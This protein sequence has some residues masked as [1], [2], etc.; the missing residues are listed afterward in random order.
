MTIKPT[1][2]QITIDDGDNGQ[3]FSPYRK[4][5]ELDR[6]MEAQKAKLTEEQHR[7][8][9]L[10]AAAL[11]KQPRHLRRCERCLVGLDETSLGAET[12]SSHVHGDRLWCPVHARTRRRE[13]GMAP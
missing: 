8:H 2:Q 1:A 12:L 11:K 3:P 6:W 4:I 10:F 9:E 13:I 5:P 7:R